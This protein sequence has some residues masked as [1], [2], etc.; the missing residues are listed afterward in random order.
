MLCLSLMSLLLNMTIFDEIKEFF[1]SITWSLFLFFIISIFLFSFGLEKTSFS[2]REYLLPL[3]SMNSFSVQIFN[4]M[5]NKLLPSGVTL[6]VTNHLDAFVSQILVSLLFAFILT[7]PFFLYFFIQYLNPALFEHEKKAILKA[8]L[9]SV[10]LF[11]GGCLF[12]YY[13][14]IPFSFKFLYSYAGVINASPFFEVSEFINSIFS[15]MFATGIM[16]LLPIFMILFSYLH[17]IDGN[18]WI[19]KWRYAFLA[20]LFFSAIITPDGTGVTMMMLFVPLSLLYVL[21][22]FFSR[23]FV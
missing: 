20:F 10:F 5:E 2:N 1:K 17:I 16:F 8:L 18:F 19:D 14:I 9:P 7:F 22:C 12:A 23:K 21:G 15:L 11:F 13:F 4:L 6:I 3:P